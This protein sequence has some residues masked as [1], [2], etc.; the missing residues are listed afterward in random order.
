MRCKM[1]SYERTDLACEMPKGLSS[2][3]VVVEKKVRGDNRIAGGR[4]GDHRP[5]SRQI[6][7]CSSGQDLADG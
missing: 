4:R 2:K 1:D 6:R 3:G 7:N 5:S